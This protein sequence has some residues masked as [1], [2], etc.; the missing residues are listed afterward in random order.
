MDAARD[1]VFID[2]ITFPATD[3]Y[4]LAGTLFLEQEPPARNLINVTQ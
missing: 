2:E 3:G 1:D 4:P